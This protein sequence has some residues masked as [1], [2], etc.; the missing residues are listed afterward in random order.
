M[1]HCLDIVI[2]IQQ[3]QDSLQIFDSFLVRLAP[4]SS[5][6]SWSPPPAAMGIPSSSSA[7]PDLAEGVRIRDHLEAVLLLG[8]NPLLL[9]PGRCIISSSGIH[10]ALFLVD[11]DLAFFVKHVGHAARRS[12]ISACPL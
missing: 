2:V 4:P 6:E 3:I 5:E 12:D 10:L 1:V 7:L 9:R 11:D 8:R